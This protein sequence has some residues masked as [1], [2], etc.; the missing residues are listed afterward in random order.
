M[1]ANETACIGRNP[2]NRKAAVTVALTARNSHATR[3]RIRGKEIKR[4]PFLLSSVRCRGREIA[5]FADVC[6]SGQCGK[7][8]G[9]KRSERE[10]GKFSELPPEKS[11]A[12]E[13]QW[14]NLRTS[15]GAGVRSTRRI[16]IQFFRPPHPTVRANA[17]V[18]ECS[19]S[20]PIIPD[21]LL[22]CFVIPGR[23]FEFSSNC[24]VIR[25]NRL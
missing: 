10:F 5:R 25:R 1:Q 20:F 8:Y 19:T 15:D 21:C 22:G 4:P 24:R 23:H 17:N 14:G 12:K 11:Q 9:R 16:N 18:E 13:I 7:S 3:V 2:A 6:E